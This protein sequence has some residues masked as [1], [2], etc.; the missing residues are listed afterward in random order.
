MPACGRK[1]W[2]LQVDVGHLRQLERGLRVGA[3]QHPVQ[4]DVGGGDGVEDGLD[5]VS[6]QVGAGAGGPDGLEASWG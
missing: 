6:A 5:L 3:G 4:L 1:G 2:G